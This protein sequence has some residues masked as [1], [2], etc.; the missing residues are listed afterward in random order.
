MQSK[1]V[2]PEDGVAETTGTVVGGTDGSEPT[3]INTMI[4]TRYKALGRGT[5]LGI[6][7]PGDAAYTISAA[8]EHAVL[9]LNDQGGEC[10]GG[11]ES[12]VLQKPYGISAYDSNAMKSSNP[13][14]GIYEA[15][16]SRTLDLNGGSPACNQGGMAVVCLEGNGQRDSHKGD[17]Y[18][19]SDIMYTLNTVEQHAIC[20]NERGETN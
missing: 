17:G 11:G 4:A 3:P 13:H 16:T 12:Y 8:H 2:Q 10:R 9:C 18:K 15:E 19:E 6:G 20:I 5:G 14:S 7:E 1:H